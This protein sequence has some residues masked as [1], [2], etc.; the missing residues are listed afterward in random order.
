MQDIYICDFILICDFHQL[1]IS[2]YF[3]KSYILMTG[4]RFHFRKNKNNI[5]S[6]QDK[7]D[8]IFDM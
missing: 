7:W 2:V 5:I 3:M 8:L 4:L 1:S 6:I